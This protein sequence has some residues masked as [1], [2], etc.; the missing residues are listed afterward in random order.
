[1]SS[2][3]SYFKSRRFVDVFD[4]KG[5]E[6]ANTRADVVAWMLSLEYKCVRIESVCN[7]IGN[8][9]RENGYWFESID[10]WR[11]IPPC[12]PP[13][14][15]MW[16]EGV[17]E[18]TRC[19][20]GIFRMRDDEDP[21]A[22]FR[23]FLFSGIWAA[24]HGLMMPWHVLE[25]SV[26]T[27]GKVRDVFQHVAFREGNDSDKSARIL[28]DRSA[29]FLFTSMHALARM[30]CANVSVRP[31]SENK[32]KQSTK[33]QPYKGIV[34]HD[35]VIDSVPT[36]PKGGHR[37]CVEVRSHW[38]R[39]HYADYTRGKGLFGNPKLRA[40][41]WIPEH[42]RGNEEVGKVISSYTVKS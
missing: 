41:F 30:N 28:A 8:T 3:Y 11:T 31:T 25:C 35:I 38:V 42:E 4:R 18:G 13:F 16:L 29:A 39:G 7:D 23:V 21:E 26:S 1:M 27:S 22:G 34:W 40:V 14:R 37:D 5:G 15:N 2:L 19:C 17:I 24:N 20:S 12:T 6:N 36:T 9:A 32:P 33:K 10:D